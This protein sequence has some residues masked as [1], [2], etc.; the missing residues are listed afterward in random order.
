M[1]RVGLH[2]GVWDDSGQH[3]EDEYGTREACLVFIITTARDGQCFCQSTVVVGFS[4]AVCVCVIEIEIGQRRKLQP[5]RR[6]FW[7]AN[8]LID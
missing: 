4:N 2:D 7:V 5:T 3:Q 6:L 1:A 8:H